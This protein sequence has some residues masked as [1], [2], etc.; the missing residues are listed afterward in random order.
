M[1]EGVLKIFFWMLLDLPE[2]VAGQRFNKMTSPVQPSCTVKSVRAVHD[3][4]KLFALE[5]S[6]LTGGQKSD[7]IYEEHILT[8]LGAGRTG[9][10]DY[11][12]AL[13][14]ELK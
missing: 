1:L 3:L 7:D 4:L 12:A 5:K 2:G 8:G 9:L 11:F 6:I 10:P 14:S 13:L